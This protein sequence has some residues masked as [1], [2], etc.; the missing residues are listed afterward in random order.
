MHFRL[1]PVALSLLCLFSAV[2]YAEEDG[3]PSPPEQRFQKVPESPQDAPIF[4][5][6][7]RVED[8]QDEQIEA[9]GNVEVRK[10]DQSVRAD[11]MLYLKGPRELQADGSV[12][13]EQNGSTVEGTRM[14]I[15]LDS[16]I[17]SMEKPVFYIRENKSHARADS[18]KFEGKLNYTLTNAEYTTCPAGKEDWVMSTT[19]LDM[20]RSRQVGEAEHAWVTWKG[21][22]LL[23][24]PWMDFSLGGQR[25]SGFLGPVFGSTAR[26]GSEVV[27]PYYWSI[28]PNRDATVSPRVMLK[29]GLQ[30][31]NEFRYLE[32]DYVGEAHLDV[33]PNDQVAR[34]TRT[35]MALKHA[36]QFGHDFSGKLDFNQVS[37][38]AYFRDLSNSITGTAQVNLMREG[39]LS[40]APSDWWNAN[41]RVQRFQT[42]QDPAAPV[43]V[44]YYRTPQL[45]VL[46]QHPLAGANVAFSGEFVDFSHPSAVNGRRLVMYPSV[47]YPLVKTAGYHLTPKVGVHS[48]SYS[49][50]VNNLAGLPATATRTLPIASLDGGVEFERDANFFGQDYV[51]TLEPR[52]YYVYIPYRNQ[53]SLPV[54]DTAQADFNFAQIFTENRFFGSDRIGDANQATLA[55]TS[56]MIEPETGAERLRLAMG[57]RFS[58]KSPQVTLNTPVSTNQSSDVLLDAFGRVSRAW[59]LNST[60]QYNPSQSRSEKLNLSTRYQPEVGK[61]LNLGYRYTRASLRQVDV[62]AQWPLSSRWHAVMR[63][64]YSLQDSQLLEALTGVEYNQDCWTVRLVA[65]RFTTSTQQTST[66]I[67]VQLELNGLVR[68]GSDPLN[69][70]RQ[71]IPGYTKLNQTHEDVPVQGLY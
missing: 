55:L 33:L 39:V 13:I 4:F 3:R 48:T 38:D 10:L 53:N 20:D 32:S 34:S 47:S 60:L 14:S 15:N 23:Y 5:Y 52:L 35:R 19:Q 17:G 44:P 59:S 57:Q 45:T 70:L 11:H 46:G 6:A 12:R 56:R 66:G 40:Y 9:T 51:Q 42:L 1:K 27:V 69:A 54:F 21:I 22:P 58:V 30:L 62:S 61:V 49:L 41:L 64:N 37:D 29:R 26:G 2:A 18:L 67:F 68:V 65:Q 36:Q 50:G 31:S 63:W 7:D 43:V 25:K 16:G 28:A 71:S 24:S 8:R